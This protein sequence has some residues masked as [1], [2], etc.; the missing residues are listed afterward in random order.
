MPRLTLSIN[1]PL[2]ISAVDQAAAADQYFARMVTRDGHHRLITI[3]RHLQYNTLVR[4]VEAARGDSRHARRT[5]RACLRR[6]HAAYDAHIARAAPAEYSALAMAQPRQPP[7]MGARAAGVEVVCDVDGVLC[8]LAAYTYRLFWDPARLADVD[9]PDKLLRLPPPAAS[10]AIQRAWADPAFWAAAPLRDG[11][12]R[13]L[14]VLQ[15]YAQVSIASAPW[16]P[17]EAWAET[18]DRWL[19]ALVSAAGA[20]PFSARHYTSQKGDL[21]GDVLIEDTLEHAQS[22]VVAPPAPGHAA[23]TAYLVD[24]PWNRGAVLPGSIVRVPDVLA[25]AYHVYVRWLAARAAAHTDP[26]LANLNRIRPGRRS[27]PKL[28]WIDRSTPLGNFNAGDA[29]LHGREH[30]V[31]SY[32]RQLD[33]KLRTRPAHRQALLIMGGKLDAGYRLAC[34][35]APAL[36]HGHVILDAIDRLRE[37]SS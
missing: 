18:R 22:F 31:A 6:I 15:R 37:G 13:A 2:L 36:C 24:H 12:A 35:C 28:L 9:R 14:L 7:L 19:D 34:W 32:A 33:D 29:V 5:T 16:P 10:D 30:T 23:R 27:D 3:D 11:A 25:A 17:C 26:R 8:D 1:V 21:P 20:Q 4:V